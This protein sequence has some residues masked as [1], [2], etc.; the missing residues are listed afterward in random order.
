MTNLK[1]LIWFCLLCSGWPLAI[2]AQVGENIEQKPSWWKRNVAVNGSLGANAMLYHAWGIPPRTQWGTWVLNGNVNIRI[3]KLNMPF[4]VIWSEQERSFQQPFNMYGISPNYKWMRWHLGY[5]TMSLS[6]FTLNGAVFFG[7][8]VELNPKKLRFAAMYGRFNRA[9]QV[10]SLSGE[11]VIP[12]YR[13]M[14]AAVKLGLGST[15]NFVDLIYFQSEDEVNSLRVQPDRTNIRPESSKVM[16]LLMKFSKGVWY[17]DTDAAFSIFNRDLRDTVQGF[18]TDVQAVRRFENW[19]GP[20]ISTQFSPAIQVATGWNFKE[21]QLRLQY[22]RVAPNYRS[23]GT[24]YFLT[25]V[26]NITVS[27]TFLLLKKKMRLAV[28]GGFQRDNTSGFKAATTIRSIGALTLSYTHSASTSTEVQV[29][30]FGTTQAPGLYPLNDSLR[31]FQV[32]R[33]VQI[34]QRWG[35]TSKTLA[36]GWTASGG[37]QSFT[38]FNNSS[39]SFLQNRILTSTLMHNHSLIAQGRQWSAGVM[40]NRVMTEIFVSNQ[41]GPSV[42]GSWTLLNKK[43]M[44][45]A[46]VSIL[47]NTINGE[48]QGLNFTLSGN[49]SY[50]LGKRQ[51]INAQ[52]NALRSNRFAGA[53]EKF[54]E[55]RLNLGYSYAF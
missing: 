1:G 46:G 54:T 38:D 16:G 53:T 23:H 5:R 47:F 28:S 15:K 37:Y 39:R 34:T 48:A 40:F 30:N 36:K 14:G 25:D 7:A 44:T 50:T 9:V 4:G 24:F 11:R 18:G 55:V 6:S 45:G 43:L 31:L 29:N 19:I 12:A 42:N 8:G 3:G 51:R 22:R 27:P 20:R 41:V 52:L 26:E 21:F 2:S 35:K 33:S 32:T 17:F 13:R 10:D 49:G